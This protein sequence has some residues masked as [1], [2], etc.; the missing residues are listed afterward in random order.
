MLTVRPR[1]AWTIE[2]VRLVLLEEGAIVA[3]RDFLFDQINCNV[4]QR[5]PTGGGMVVGLN[6]PLLFRLFHELGSIDFALC[7]I[8]L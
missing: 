8:R 1:A 2:A 5:T 4:L 6:P 3:A 7:G